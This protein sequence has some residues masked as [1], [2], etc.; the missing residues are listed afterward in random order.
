MARSTRRRVTLPRMD[1]SAMPTELRFD[2]PRY[3]KG[4]A[5]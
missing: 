5:G 4:T 3:L 1:A 2:L